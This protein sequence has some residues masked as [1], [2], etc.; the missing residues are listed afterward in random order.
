MIQRVKRLAYNEIKLL[1]MANN[2]II[3]GGFVRDEIIGEYYIDMFNK[4][5]GCI[6]KF[7]DTSYMP[8]SKARTIIADDMDISFANPDDAENFIN[9]LKECKRFN[10]IDINEEE[11]KYYSNNVKNIREVTM[12]IVMGA[13]P[14]VFDEGH[15][16]YIKADVVI[17]RNNSL[18]PPFRNLDM[19]C[20]GFILKKDSR[21][22][23]SPHT[24]TILDFYTDIERA[25]AVAQIMKDMKDFK[26]ALCFVSM[27]PFGR[28]KR[29]IMAMKRIEKMEKKKF[30]WN[31][32]NMPFQVETYHSPLTQDQ[33][34]AATQS[35]QPSTTHCV[36]S[37][38]CS[39]CLC[40]LKEGDK[41]AYTT[42]TTKDNVVVNCAPCHYKCFMKHLKTQSKNA[43]F[44][45]HYNK[46]VF[47]CP[48]RNKIDFTRSVIDIQ[49]IYKCQI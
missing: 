14:F 37:V 22:E 33:Q 30:K 23:F 13:I 39:I 32:I 5:D 2:G 25:Y 9:A 21:K 47:T 6:D 28:F 10:K 20:N 31:F 46:F 43:D 16:I 12:E 7:W 40:H 34:S 45:N 8:E 15:K 41:I 48:Y 24:G 35:T 17:P 19:L 4:A 26:T 11:D 49:F 18:Q 38:D 3:F 1:A 36:D 44:M 29:N 42:S 27:S